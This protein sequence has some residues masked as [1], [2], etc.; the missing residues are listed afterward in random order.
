VPQS[1]SHCKQGPNVVV[2]N[3]S[4]A[5]SAPQ[6]RQVGPQSG[7][8]LIAFSF[9]ALPTSCLLPSQSSR[10]AERAARPQAGQGLRFQAAAK[11]L[12][13]VLLFLVGL[14]ACGEVAV[15]LRHEILLG[16]V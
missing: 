13:T 4:A 7:L 12:G 5:T 1:E 14:N 2:V 11:R 16:I 9:N 6:T 10:E 3:A 8:A 15:F